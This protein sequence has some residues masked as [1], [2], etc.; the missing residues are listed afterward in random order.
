MKVAFF[1]HAP[2]TFNV[3]G[4]LSPNVPVTEDGKNIAKAMAGHVD[5]VICSTLRR[6]RE[7]LDHSNLKYKKVIFTELCR[8]I[9]DGNTSNLYNKE[10]NVVETEEDVNARIEKFRTFLFSQPE[11]SSEHTN[12]AVI[13]HSTFL[14]KMTGR[15]FGNCQCHILTI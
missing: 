13:S 11:I 7:T 4:D 3:N 6:A 1:R 12:I 15:A 10:D 9:L 2:S 8:E 5:L 14:Y